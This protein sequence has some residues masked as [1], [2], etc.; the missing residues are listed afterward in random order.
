MKKTKISIFAFTVSCLLQTSCFA[1]TELTIAPISDPALTHLA[2]KAIKISNN[3][4]TPIK[5]SVFNITG[6]DSQ[7]SIS[8]ASNL[9]NSCKINQTLGTTAKDNYCYLWLQA[10]LKGTD[11]LGK[12]TFP[13]SVNVNNQ[14]S[15][16]N[17]TSENALY[18]GG[19]FNRVNTT[20]TQS[21]P[22]NN[23]AKWNGKTW[24]LLGTPGSNGVDR[25]V[26]TIVTNGI[27]IYIGG[28]FTKAYSQT[29]ELPTKHLAR[30][31][32]NWVTIANGPDEGYDPDIQAMAIGK[33]TI[34]AGG[35]N[36]D[37]FIVFGRIEKDTYYSL[38]GPSVTG[39][40]MSLA[41][42]PGSD[43]LYTVGRNGDSNFWDVAKGTWQSLAPNL[44]DQTLYAVTTHG[45]NVYFGGT[46]LAPASG[47]N[48][49]VGWDTAGKTFTKL[50][51]DDQ[52]LRSSD[53]FGVTAFFQAG[54]NLVIAGQFDKV[55]TK[56]GDID[57]N[58]I[59]IW[60][61]TTKKWTK[62][63]NGAGDVAYDCLYS[64]TI[65]GDKLYVGG[66]IT[67]IGSLTIN[68]IAMWDLTKNIWSALGAGVLGEYGSG[69]VMALTS[70]SSITIE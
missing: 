21:L 10:K 7:N 64:T 48:Y 60:N 68:S 33:S 57:L 44:G 6:L 20:V 49:L 15:K 3:Q 28:L 19:T 36:D 51:P 69:N 22:A 66:T 11:N 27:D 41:I 30:W 26:N 37:G 56:G 5:L 67:N 16:Y 54:D 12:N 61:F 25:D 1:N 14:T 62:L 39:R 18:V 40:I 35:G 31:N 23:I 42:K 34:Y 46:F 70:A 17:I 59:G 9:E 63:G 43:D 13:I 24:E 50:N 29:G 52:G 55:S 45:N 65:V 58:N 8:I 53:G 2:L 47:D 38:L 4:N 32:G